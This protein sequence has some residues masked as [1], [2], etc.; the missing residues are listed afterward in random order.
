[1]HR[2]V[3]P[4]A[5]GIAVLAAVLVVS[6]PVKTLAALRGG[7]PALVVL[8][9]GL[10]VPAVLLRVVRW[11]LMIAPVAAL[12][13]AEV[14]APVT[15]GYMA[16]NLL[17]ARLGYILRAVLAARR[18]GVDFPFALGTVVVEKLVEGVILVAIGAAILAA[19]PTSGALRG[20]L[21]LSALAFIGGLVVLWLL[22]PVG[23]RV[24]GLTG[25]CRPLWRL[26]PA[27]ASARLSHWLLSLLAGL[28][29]LRRLDLAGGIAG[30]SIVSWLIEGAAYVMAFAA[31]VPDAPPAVLIAGPVLVM[32]TANIGGAL[33]PSPAAVGTFEGIGVATLA[34]LGVEEAR[35]LSFLLAYHAA[36]VVVIVGMGLLGLWSEGL[37]FGQA[38]AG[39]RH[40]SPSSISPA[41]PS[42]AGGA[43]DPH[44]PVAE[45]HGD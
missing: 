8:S 43:G 37:S 13:V 2:T 32:V 30:L 35:A 7:N 36:N 34:L 5:I 29:G 25:L 18:R 22:A 15:V 40:A 19:V 4:V 44:V 17:P 24:F 23:E 31:F 42:F 14:Y 11:K 45:G 10:V 39:A 1:M 33:V 20:G 16:N 27:H 41:R 28:A 3:L 6:D 9:C 26:L 21:A 38:I 12:S